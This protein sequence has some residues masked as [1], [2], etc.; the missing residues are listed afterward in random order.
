MAAE[1]TDPEIQPPEAPVAAQPEPRAQVSH[2]VVYD[3]SWKLARW[4]EKAPS[5][6]AL[7][8]TIR[9]LSKERKIGYMVHGDFRLEERFKQMRRDVFDMYNVLENGS[10]V[11]IEPGA[12]SGE[13][14]VKMVGAVEGTKRKMGVVPI[15]VQRERL[16]IKTVEWE[17]R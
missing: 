6:E 16:L 14:K 12:N 2:E 11:E 13:W 9:R 8:A 1:S 5:P 17:D 10:I 3:I 4:P 15:V 7:A